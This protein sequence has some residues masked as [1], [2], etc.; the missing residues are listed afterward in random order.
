MTHFTGGINGAIMGDMLTTVGNTVKEDLDMLRKLNLE[1]D[2][3]LP[4]QQ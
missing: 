1:I 3:T 4:S 2:S